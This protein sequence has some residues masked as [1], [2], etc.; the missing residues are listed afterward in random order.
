[1]KNLCFVLLIAIALVSCE[2][3]ISI[4]ELKTFV[5]AEGDA[6]KVAIQNI[7]RDAGLNS[8]YFF[9]LHELNFTVRAIFRE[10]VDEVSKDDMHAVCNAVQLEI[11]KFDDK[12]ESVLIDFHR[13]RQGARAYKATVP[14]AE[15]QLK[16]EAFQLYSSIRASFSEAHRICSSVAKAKK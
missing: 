3:E 6:T 11:E 12:V 1:M 9:R 7:F 16:Q 8:A 10:N 5:Q 15:Y 4:Y 13:Y 2:E 14:A